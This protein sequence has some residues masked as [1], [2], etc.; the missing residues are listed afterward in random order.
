[1]HFRYYKGTF[2]YVIQLSSR[3]GTA[4][5]LSV[6]LDLVSYLVGIGRST[7]L[8]LLSFTQGLSKG[9][10]FGQFRNYF[11]YSLSKQDSLLLVEAGIGRYQGFGRQE[12]FIADLGVLSRVC[13]EGRYCSTSRSSIVCSELYQ[14]QEFSL[15]IGVIVNISSQVTVYNSISVLSLAISFGVLGYRIRSLNAQRVTK[16][17]L[18]RRGELRTPIGYYSFQQA[19]V[20]VD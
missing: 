11:V 5:V 1:M 8:V 2:G 7:V 15:I 20:A 19:V 10:L 9:Y 6:Q 16:C 3:S 4:E 13:K 12:G 18:E 17:F 14:R